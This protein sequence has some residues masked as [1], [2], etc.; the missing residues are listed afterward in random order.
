MVRQVLE[1]VTSL[2]GDATESTEPALGQSRKVLVGQSAT[3][4]EVHLEALNQVVQAYINKYE[5]E[6]L[7]T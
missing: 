5:T 2:T 3:Q 6:L 1:A 7:C 4:W